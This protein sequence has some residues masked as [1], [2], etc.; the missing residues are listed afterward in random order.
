MFFYHFDMLVSKKKY[1]NI[2]SSE[3]HFKNNIYHIFKQATASKKFTHLI[4]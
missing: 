1:F 2:F 3:K 4:I